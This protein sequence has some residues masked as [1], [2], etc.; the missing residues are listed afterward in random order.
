ML[1][2]RDG[3]N[4]EKSDSQGRVPLWYATKNGHVRVVAL[5]QRLTSATYHTA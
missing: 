4:P 1:L 2:E 3:I 5:L